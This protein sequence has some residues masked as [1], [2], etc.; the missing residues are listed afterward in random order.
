MCQARR[1]SRP[2]NFLPR[3]DEGWGPVQRIRNQYLVHSLHV[4]LRAG[5]CSVELIAQQVL[6]PF[7]TLLLIRCDVDETPPVKGTSSPCQ[8]RAHQSR[9]MQ[10]GPRYQVLAANRNQ[11]Q[12]RQW[13]QSERTQAVEHLSLSAPVT[14]IP[15]ATQQAISGRRAS[16]LLSTPAP[17][18]HTS[19]G[20]PVP[21]PAPSGREPEGANSAAALPHFSRSVVFTGSHLPRPTCSSLL[22]PRS[23]TR[24]RQIRRRRRSPFPFPAFHSTYLHVR[25]PG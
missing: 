21:S 11:A 14:D 4:L 12:P 10:R 25:G 13:S 17:L 22:L 5:Q 24:R 19:P 18:S 23:D 3:I 6:T 2:R 16:T 15:A 9:R 20:S 7:T 1:G 8:I